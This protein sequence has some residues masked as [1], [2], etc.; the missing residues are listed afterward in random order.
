MAKCEHCGAEL[1]ESGHLLDE[2]AAGGGQTIT[3]MPSADVK[4]ARKE[5]IA[6]IKSEREREARR[7]ESSGRVNVCPKCGMAGGV[8]TI[9]DLPRANLR[10][11]HRKLKEEI[12]EAKDK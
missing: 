4:G 1:T 8:Q 11:A 12:R 7:E 3:D 10:E 6:E 5:L 9:S 2:G